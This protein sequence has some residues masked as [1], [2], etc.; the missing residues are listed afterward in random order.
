MELRHLRILVTLA[1]E[2]HF[3]R[4]AT[5]L[6]VAQSAVSQ[7]VQA[8]ESELG[9]VL[10]ERTRRRVAL[11]V[12]GEQLVEHGRRA[13]AELERGKLATARAAAG[14]RGVLRVRFTPASA[15]TTLPQRVVSFKREHPEVDVNVES[16]GL[17]L[18][19]V[20][21]GACDVLFTPVRG[22]STPLATHR[23]AR[24]AL[25]VMLARNHALARRKQLS[26]AQLADEPFVFVRRE[27]EPD[28][29]E[30][31]VRRC[32]AAGF[33]PRIV[34][35]ATS[36]EVLLAFIAAGLG[37]SVMPSLVT[38]V[39]FPGVKA[40]PLHPTVPATIHAVWNPERT[41]PVTGRFLSWLRA[42]H[43]EA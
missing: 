27:S 22:D 34:L 2:L 35:H 7:A 40:V 16:A 38:R 8:L 24:Y 9:V 18:E 4:T 21:D 10:F 1:E 43:R 41:S 32:A 29:S 31:F 42:T 3:G 30:L 20:R 25:V 33:T 17:G 36:L 5:R 37:I 26:L 15:L 28:I 39:G 12:A 11:S 14:Q 23:V 6:R 19:A 13:L